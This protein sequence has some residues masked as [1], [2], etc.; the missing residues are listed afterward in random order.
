MF[1]ESSKIL[2]ILPGRQRATPAAHRTTQESVI[3]RISPAIL[4]SSRADA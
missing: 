1:S 4:A 2:R 3:P